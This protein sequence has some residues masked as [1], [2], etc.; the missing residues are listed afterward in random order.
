MWGLRTFAATFGNKKTFLMPLLRVPY[1]RESPQLAPEL[2]ADLRS[3][4]SEAVEKLA[5]KG[6]VHGD[7]RWPNVAFDGAGVVLIDMV[8]ARSAVPYDVA[9]VEMTAQVNV[10]FSEI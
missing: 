1:T 6:V 9:L 4:I 7:I 10:L 8:R 5:R 2:V 3:A